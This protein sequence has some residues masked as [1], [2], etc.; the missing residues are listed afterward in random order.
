MITGNLII[1][2]QAPGLRAP[3]PFQLA[4]WGSTN[5]YSNVLLD[6][7]VHRY[8]YS[9]ARPINIFPFSTSAS[10]DSL[11]RR[12]RNSGGGSSIISLTW[13]LFSTR[14]QPAPGGKLD[15]VLIYRPYLGT[16]FGLQLQPTLVNIKYRST[17][18]FTQLSIRF[19]ISNNTASVTTSLFWSHRVDVVRPTSTSILFR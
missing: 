1:L 7:V 12:I 3:P 4:I 18:C 2:L 6:H 19:W 11:A 14:T 13:P 9:R 5:R 8:Q 10:P 15:T 17:G 16:I